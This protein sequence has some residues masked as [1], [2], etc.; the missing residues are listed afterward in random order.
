MTYPSRSAS[1]LLA[2]FGASLLVLLTGC[3]LSSSPANSPHPGGAERTNTLFTAFDEASP[4]Y[5]DP[6]SSYASNETPITYQVYEPLYRYHY[7][8]RPYV[9]EGRSAEAVAQPRYYDKAGRELPAT[10]PGELVA[11]SVYDVKIRKGIRFAPHPA[12]AKDGQG[13]YR[14]HGLKAEDLEGKHQIG[15]FP[16]TGTR[17]LVAEDFVYAIKRLATTRVKSPAFSV[18]AEYIVGL[19]EYGDLIKAEDRKLRAGIAPTQ[20][21]LPFLDFRQ[22]PLAGATALDSHTLRIRVK[23]KYPQFKYWLQ[24][25]FFAPI[26]WEAERFYANPGMAERN[27][28]LNFWPA[29]TGPYMAT[30]YVENRRHVMV[31][32]PNFRGEPYP[33]E[34]EPADRAAGL[35]ADCGKTTPFIDKVVMIL[36]KEGIPNENKFIQGYLDEPDLF[37]PEW[38]IKFE[39]QAKD[40]DARARLFE[41]RGLRFPKS[42]ENTNWYMGF[43]WW[44]PVVGKG[45]TPE[46]QARNRKLRSALQIAVDWEEYAQVFERK[47]GPP[48]HGPLPPAVFGYRDGKEGMNPVAYEWKDGRAVRRSLDEAKKLLA[49]AGYPNGRDVRTGRPLV[50]NYDYQRVPTPELKAEIDWV[51]KQFAKLGIQLEVRATDFNRFQDKMDSGSAQIF[52]WGWLAD[53]PDAENFLFLLYGPNSKAATQGNGENATNYQNDEFDRLYQK[54]RYLEDGPEKQKVIDRMVAIVQQDS[55]WLWGFNPYAAGAYHAWMSNAKPTQMVRDNVQYRRIDPAKRAAA[56]A[57][58]NRPI[59]WP[60]GL[61]ALACLAFLWPAWRAWQ[62]RERAT[63]RPPATSAVSSQPAAA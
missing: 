37:H 32:N 26:P 57:R 16:E 35:L 31:R 46:E 19:K 10:A 54:M 62:R 63:A 42:V 39:G 58:W 21:D 43:N 40:S 25:T 41:E 60:L 29:G 18:M 14:Y 47:A 30:E 20:R 59:A 49:E 53:Y 50:L 11:E 8:K 3:E 27:F 36:E 22:W 44:D 61:V 1:R 23:S 51:V 7:L 5:L 28:T 55:P 12:F 6:T 48:A 38:G 34:G 52:W 13:R 56:I 45:K 17:E 4:K 15:D 24:M 2:W 9:L 33:C